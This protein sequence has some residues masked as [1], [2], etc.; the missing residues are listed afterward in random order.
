MTP[1]SLR[2]SHL[3]TRLRA[4]M[5]LVAEAVQEQVTKQDLKAA[6]SLAAIFERLARGYSLVEQGRS[7]S[8]EGVKCRGDRDKSSLENKRTPRAPR[9]P[10]STGTPEYYKD[11][12]FRDM[13]APFPPERRGRVEDAWACWLKLPP[14]GRQL[15]KERIGEYVAKVKDKTYLTQ[16]TAWVQNWCIGKIEDP[17]DDA[18]E[19]T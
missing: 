12:D 13:L 3:L 6:D 4:T 1:N 10:K 19:G 17:E 9:K 7:I 16:F 11:P 5:L 8:L 2:R 15:L 14:G 18:H